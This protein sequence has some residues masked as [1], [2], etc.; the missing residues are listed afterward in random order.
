MGKKSCAGRN[1]AAANGLAKEAEMAKLN[2]SVTENADSEETKKLATKALLL[3]RKSIYKN[4]LVFSFSYLLQFS[5]INGLH[6]LQSTLNSHANLG[7]ITLLVSSI[8]FMISCLFLPIILCKLAGFKW[9]L[10]CA[11][12]GCLFF[13]VANYFGTFGTLLPSA[14]LYGASLSVIWIFQGS[15]IA[16]LSNEYAHLT[17]RNKEKVMM[18]FYAIFMIIF[19]IRNYI[20]LR[21]GV[22]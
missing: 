18:K 9:S 14:P 21:C 22:Y 16:H 6:N 13:I 15:F 19:Q 17:K 8:T 12:L 10:V 20:V 11:Q 3:R 4:L 5:A 1:K 2:S 7:I